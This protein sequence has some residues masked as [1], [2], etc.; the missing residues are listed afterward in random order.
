VLS[1]FHTREARKLF[2]YF[3]AV[4]FLSLAIL[5]TALFFRYFL[6]RNLGGSLRTSLKSWAL[7]LLLWEGVLAL[8]V[9]YAFYRLLA[10]YERYRMEQEEFLRLLL[11]S[12]SHKFG[13]FLSAQKVNLEIL[14]D[15]PSKE[16]VTRL[17]EACRAMEGDLESLI[18]LLKRSLEGASREKPQGLKEYIEGLLRRFEIQ[19]G[20]RRVHLSFRHAPF[21]LTPE[22]E[23]VLFFLLENAFRHSRHHIWIRTGRDYILIMNDLSPHPV[24]GTGLGLYL[25]QKLLKAD[26]RIHLV[27]YRK[28]GLFLA[29]LVPTKM[30][31]TSTDFT[32]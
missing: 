6:E 10:A 19:F 17:K 28:K 7:Y 13:N 18:E 30:P 15:S 16:A 4:L 26:K 12:L 2:L 24:Q 8:S 1:R 25:S 22:L 14:E 32:R 11:A 31:R 21:P 27:L 5:F 9:S 23:L 3:L 29:L 20:S